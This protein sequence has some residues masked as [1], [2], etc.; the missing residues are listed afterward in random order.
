MEHTIGMIME[1]TEEVRE[2]R[3]DILTSQYEA[4]KSLPGESVTQVF[5]RFN[6][7]INELSIQGKTYPLRETNRKFMLT[8]P[9]HLEHKVSSI[10]ERNDFN[11][12]SLEKLYGKL[13]THEME[14][15][16]GRSFM[17]LEQ[18]T[19]RNDELLKTTALTASSYREPK[20]KAVKPQNKKDEIFEAEMD[21]GDLQCDE[22]EYYTL[23]SCSRWKIL[24]WLPW[25]QILVT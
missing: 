6:R 7:L 19:A 18:W 17:V 25:L 24:P 16:R 11:T 4:F 3:L 15:N 9:A 13:K 1:G 20:A 8:L 5:E 10:R 12:L 22:S 23:K 21:D 14:Q 2:N